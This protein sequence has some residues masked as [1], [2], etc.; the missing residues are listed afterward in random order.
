MPGKRRNLSRDEIALSEVNIKRIQEFLD[1]W[2]DE[3]KICESHIEFIIDI[4]ARKAKKDFTMRLKRARM[5]KNQ[6]E[7]TIK[8]LQEQIKNGV[9]IK[10]E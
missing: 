2:N 4:N 8:T 7:Q 3:I 5:E 9:E 1:D 6:A 10:E